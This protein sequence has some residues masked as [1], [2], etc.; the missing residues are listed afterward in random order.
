MQGTEKRTLFRHYLERGVWKSAIAR[1]LDI[2][3][4]TIHRW[5][6]EGELERDIDTD[7]PS[8]T[9]RPPVSTKLDPYKPIIETRLEALPELSA[10]PLLEEIRAA[11]YEGGY[12]E[13]K[14]YVRTIRPREDKVII[15][16]ETP[17]GYQAGT[18]WADPL[19]IVRG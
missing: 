17:P 5:I 9:P 7:P 6:R 2:S 1:H 15:R 19:H 3:R 13:L 11:G 8:Y 4:E 14:E 12:T 10:V 18:Y 16:S